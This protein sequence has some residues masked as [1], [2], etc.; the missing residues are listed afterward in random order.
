MAGKIEKIYRLHEVLKSRRTPISRQA[1]MER[2]GCSQATLYRLVAALRDELGAPLEQHEES[3]D[4]FYDRTLGNFEL[5]GV[6]LSPDEI[7]ALVAARALLARVQPGLLDEELDS[8]RGRMTTLLESRGLPQAH[9]DRVVRIVHQASR[10]APRET[11]RAAL[12]SLTGQRRMHIAYRDRST[13]QATTREISPQ[14]LTCYREN[15]YLDA[16]C[17]LRQ[18]LR[19][20][21]LDRINVLATPTGPWHSIPTDELNSHFQSSY[22]I[23]AGPAE[24][25]AVLR[26]SARMARWVEGERWHSKQ[27]SQ[28]LGDGRFELCVPFGRAEELTMDILRY[29]EEVEVVAPDFLRDA[30][31]KKHQA[32]AAQYLS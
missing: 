3:R 10:D 6:W 18:G 8:L 16:W 22:G 31:L 26:F 9:L 13:D 12:D 28:K 2:L 21:A 30:V 11:F 20:F 1:L 17:H 29:G 15:W 19:S 5:P 14:R 23:F 4:F 27:T 24:N 25:T 32:A 7:Q